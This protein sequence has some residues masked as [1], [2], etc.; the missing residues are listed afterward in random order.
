VGVER[1]FAH[2]VADPDALAA[3]LGPLA[4][5]L[6]GRLDRH[7][8]AGRTLTLKI[9]DRHFQLTSRSI[10]VDGA[11]FAA[12]DLEAL[13]RALLTHPM[14]PPEPVRLLGLTVSALLPR[15]GAGR[16]LDQWRGVEGPPAEQRA[17]PT[18]HEVADDASP[19]D[20]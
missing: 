16:Q 14:P 7:G 5:E 12:A 10:T 4:E 8:V 1:T 3:R 9:K 13:G 20:L 18:V 6:A 15:D 2:D 11:L 17:A 19:A